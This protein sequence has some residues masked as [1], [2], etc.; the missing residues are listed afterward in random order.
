MATEN[1]LSAPPRLPEPPIITRPPL[2][3]LWQV[4]LFVAGLL[5]VVGV[6]ATRPLWYDA[7]A[8][9]VQRDLA[10]ARL[11]VE[12]PR[13]PANEAPGLITGALNH[14]DHCP[15]RAGEAHFLLGKAYVRLAG[16]ISNGHTL[17]L[18]Q[19]AR[20]HLE[21][22]EKLGVPE[23]DQNAL[24]YCLG[25]ALFKTGGDAQRTITNLLLSVEQAAEDRAEG[26][27]MLTA[28]YL[29]PRL[30]VRDLKSALQWNQKQLDLPTP[31]E[32]LLA[33]VRLQRGELLLQPGSSSPEPEARRQDR[34]NARKVLA[35]IGP[36]AAPAI[37][38]RARRLQARSYMD[39]QAWANAAEIWEKILADRRETQADLP[40]VL[41]ALGWCYY[42]VQRPV[43]ASRA[44]EKI[45]A[46]AGEEGQAASLRLADLHR[47]VGDHAAAVHL[48]EHALRQVDRADDYQNKLLDLEQ[49]REMLDTGCQACLQAKRFVEAQELAHLAAKLAP[50]HDSL[51]LLAE[52]MEA[53]ARSERDQSRKE[54]VPGAAQRGAEA[55]QHHFREAAAAYTDAAEAAA[56]APRKLEMLWLASEDYREGKD[57]VHQANVLHSYLTQHPPAARLSEAWFRLGEAHQALGFGREAAESYKNCVGCPGPYAFAARYQLALIQIE[58]RNPVEAEEMLRQNLELMRVE[59]DRAAHEKTIYAYASLLCLRRDFRAAAQRWEQA[60]KEYPG[61][62]DALTARYWLGECYRQL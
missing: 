17:D 56:D 47:Q 13:T 37:V 14:I 27:A 24:Q 35:R 57:L 8:C 59:T 19:Q 52:V 32:N 43:D 33:P 60:L 2:G 53:W 11:I 44:W 45:I 25:K 34:E 62:A 30:P 58:Q 15:K 20:V 48:V 39:D 28:A 5:A 7:Q 36:G 16:P 3:Q 49:A 29:D 4:P 31:D 22:A 61:N 9:Q 51:V 10:R 46:Y 55:A 23:A 50:P 12:N 26:Y 41:Y 6:W 1:S 42:N 38:A 18:W 21:Q 54:K 40:A